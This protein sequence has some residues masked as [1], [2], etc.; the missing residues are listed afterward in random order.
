MKRTAEPIR[1]QCSGSRPVAFRR[2]AR[3]GRGT[4]VIDRILRVWVVQSAWW[5]DEVRHVYY[6]VVSGGSVFLLCR[7]QSPRDDWLMLGIHD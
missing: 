3:R 4:Y 1:V 2:T 5:A 6:L 7:R